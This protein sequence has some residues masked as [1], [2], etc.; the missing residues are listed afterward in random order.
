M[1]YDLVR[2]LSIEPDLQPDHS[3]IRE[4][5]NFGA[6][7]LLQFEPLGWPLKFFYSL[8][9]L[10]EVLIAILYSQLRVEVD[11]F[12]LECECLFCNIL[13]PDIPPVTP[14]RLSEFDPHFAFLLAIFGFL[15]KLPLRLHGFFKNLLQTKLD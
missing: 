15:L 11:S 2:P 1:H 3:R 7:T 10:V 5:V 13:D 6:A 8:S 9:R 12:L 4:R 14:R